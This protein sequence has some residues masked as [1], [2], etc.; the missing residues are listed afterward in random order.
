MPSNCPLCHSD[1]TKNFVFQKSYNRHFFE[2]ENCSLIY[3]DRKELLSVEDEKSRY[4]LHENHIRTKGYEKFLRRL[5]N[6]LKK[7]IDTKDEGLDFG[8]GP[9]PMLREIFAED[10][11]QNIKGY[12]PIYNNNARSLQGSYKFITCCE[13]IEHASSPKNVWEEILNLLV[14][15]DAYIAL[16]TGIYDHDFDFLKWQYTHDDTH[17]N[18]FTQKTIEWISHIYHLEIIE[19]SKDFNLF[20]RRQKVAQP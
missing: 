16:S 2:C 17:I 3:V 13:V 18:F 8:E 9:Y 19:S 6:P 1:N 20:L 15:E 14:C 4:D 12:D 5:I 10:G 7:Y 11:Y